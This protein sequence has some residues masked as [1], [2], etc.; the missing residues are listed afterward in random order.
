MSVKSLSSSDSRS[1]CSF[2]SLNDGSNLH[3]NI[4]HKATACGRTI[5]FVREKPDLFESY[6]PARTKAKN[7]F[8]QHKKEIMYVAGAVLAIELMVLIGKLAHDA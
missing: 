1:L 4:N 3:G 2:L 7:I 6:V 8:D 5:S